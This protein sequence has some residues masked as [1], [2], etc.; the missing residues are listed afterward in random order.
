MS[1]STNTLPLSLV[2]ITYK[3][4]GMSFIYLVL[5]FGN[6]LIW[7]DVLDKRG[8]LLCVWLLAWAFNKEEKSENRIKIAYNYTTHGEK[9]LYISLLGHSVEKERC[10]FGDKWGKKL[11]ASCFLYDSV[12]KHSAINNS[13]LI[14]TSFEYGL[15]EYILNIGNQYLW[16]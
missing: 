10:G 7:S 6:Q 3:E 14:N 16:Y 9:H 13:Y 11:I 8:V 12:P 4:G 15:Q 1:F 2:G 5:S